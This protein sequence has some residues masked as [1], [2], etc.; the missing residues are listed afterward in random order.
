[1]RNQEGEQCINCRTERT[2]TAMEKLDVRENFVLIH[3]SKK[4]KRKKI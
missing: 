4:M 1:M 3:K 2:N